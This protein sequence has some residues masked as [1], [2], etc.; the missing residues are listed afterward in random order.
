[1]IKTMTAFTDEVDD[2]DIA[3]EEI[4]GQLD[5]DGLL[6]ESVGIVNCNRDF[7]ETDVLSALS[8]RL[9]FPIVGATSNA[10]GVKGSDSYTNPLSL[11]VLTSDTLRFRT[12]M[13]GELVPETYQDEIRRACGAAS[14]G[15]EGSPSLVFAYLPLLAKASGTAI[16]QSLCDSVGKGVP[17]FGMVCVT[18]EL[19][20]ASSSV[21]LAGDFR[22][23]CMSM[24]LIY[25]DVKPQFFQGTISEEK[26]FKSNGVISGVRDG[27]VLES[28]SGKTAREFLK[29]VGVPTSE[30]GEIL[31]PPV[32]PLAVDYNDGSPALLRAMI[33]NLPDGSMLLGADVPV[34]ATLS[35]SNIDYDEVAR[36]ARETMKK[37]VSVGDFSV[38]I[39]HSCASRYY[40]VEGIDSELEIRIV[41]EHLDSKAGYL[42]SFT[43][44][45]ICPVTTKGGGMEA[46]YHNFTIVACVF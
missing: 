19:D 14:E 10:C 12:G 42:F 2:V 21:L 18:E 33:C 20:H 15:M 7:I 34:G 30:N 37:V 27:S 38:A 8:E 46:R 40:V 28:V 36:V 35:V 25:G 39:V 11:L 32:F 4:L 13:T 9:P 16:V 43:G 31:S 45:E 41:R 23:D 29:D 1:M 24:V 26:Y 44:G 6:A 17:V 5:L 3:L 22:K